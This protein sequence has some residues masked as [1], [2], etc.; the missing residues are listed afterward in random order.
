MLRTWSCSLTKK[1]LNSS[2]PAGARLLTLA[3]NTRNIG[4]DEKIL[5]LMAMTRL[6]ARI[7]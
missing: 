6:L 2:P 5:N 4:D 1:Y 7:D 3:D